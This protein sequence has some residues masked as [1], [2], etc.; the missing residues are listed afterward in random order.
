M[1]LCLISYTI[2]ESISKEIHVH[3]LC[4]GDGGVSCSTHNSHDVETT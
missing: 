1:E 3:I 2:W 4:Q